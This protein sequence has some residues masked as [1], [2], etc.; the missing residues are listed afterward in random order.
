M[1]SMKYLTPRADKK[2]LIFL[3]G[4][5]WCMVGVMLLRY[6]S[7]WLINASGTDKLIFVPL[8]LAAAVPIYRLGFLKLA[9]KNLLRLLPLES[10]RCLFSFMTWKSY[11]IVPVMIT[12]GITLRNSPMPKTWLSIIYTGIGLGLFLSGLQYMRTLV[13][14]LVSARQK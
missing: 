6:A 13:A 11:L 14:L 10:P 4:L 3:A 12:M 2:V 1:L 7:L 8:G 5:M 9:E